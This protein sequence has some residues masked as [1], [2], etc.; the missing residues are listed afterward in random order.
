MFLH[1]LKAYGKST[2]VWSASLVLLIVFFLSF[3]P[4]IANEAAEFKKI[5]ANYPEPVRKAF[6][7]SID[8][9]SS[10]LGFYAY[11]FSYIL[12]CGSIQAMNLGISVLSKETR[13]KT[14]DFLLTKPVTRNEVITAKLAAAL[15]SLMITNIIYVA[16]AAATASAVS[17][18]AVDMNIF[19]LISL[20]AFLVELMFLALGIFIAVIVPKIKSVLSLS[21]SIVFAFFI[22]NMFGS[23]IGEK[24]IR[25]ITPFKYY[26]T[27]YIMKHSGYETSFLIIEGLFIII[28]IV[29]S[30]FIY[31]KKDIHTV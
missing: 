22:I 21:L 3:F 15:A 7:L 14:A 1:E 6:G 9:I 26:D 27:A 29:A 8:T 5:L 12:L 11:A 18:K 10:L 13:E 19:I 16:A 25:Y 20:T 28:A 4:S 31:S 17:E 24:A 30:Y 2:M 23:V